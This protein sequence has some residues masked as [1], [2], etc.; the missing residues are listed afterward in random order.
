[1]GIPFLHCLILEGDMHM[2]TQM[3]KG[4]NL[5][6][7]KSREE[8]LEIMLHEVYGYLPPKPEQLAL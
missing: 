8:M 1:M 4:R 2:L 7:L 5:P 6:P 3:L